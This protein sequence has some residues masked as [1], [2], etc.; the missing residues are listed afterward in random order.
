MPNK[1]IRKKHFNHTSCKVLRFVGKLLHPLNRSCFQSNILQEVS[2]PFIVSF[3]NVQENTEKKATKLKSNTFLQ[4]FHFSSGPINS[5]DMCKNSLFLKTLSYSY[6]QAVW[7][8]RGP[9]K[10]RVS[11]QIV[12]DAIFVFV[13]LVLVTVSEVVTYQVAFTLRLRLPLVQGTCICAGGRY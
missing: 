13:Y 11:F 3:V 10:L 9:R 8:C 5:D 1:Q 7:F 2:I 12:S 4:G 6:S